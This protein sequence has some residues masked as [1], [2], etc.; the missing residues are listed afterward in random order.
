[1]LLWLIGLH[2]IAIAWY[3]LFRG[4]KLLGA[5]FHGNRDLPGAPPSVQP[6]SV[7]RLIIGV[8]LAVGFTWLVTRAFQ[9]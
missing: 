9:L 2:I 6:V 8:L 4:E 5:M 7:V 1:M 3:R